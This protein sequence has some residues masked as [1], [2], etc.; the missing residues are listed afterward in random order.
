M[1]PPRQVD[2]IQIHQFI[3]TWKENGTCHLSAKNGERIEVKITK[4]MVEKALFITKGYS[5]FVNPKLA[6][7]EKLTIFSTLTLSEKN[8]ETYL[9]LDEI[10]LAIHV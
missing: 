1:L 2:P 3:T 7:K 5:N 10:T 9:V 6:T 4:K 8:Y